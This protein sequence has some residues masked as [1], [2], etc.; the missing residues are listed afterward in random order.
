MFKKLNYSIY[1]T[2]SIYLL[3]IGSV[4]ACSS[5]CGTAFGNYGIGGPITTTPAY[6]L[7]QGKFVINTSLRY[8]NVD[9]FSNNTFRA[10]D[11]THTHA[12][13]HDSEMKTIATL[14][15]GITD[16]FTI[17][18]SY[19]YRFL[20]GL[21]T[22]EEDNNIISGGNSIG[23][24]DM[25]LLAKYR[26]L[27]PPLSQRFRLQAA[28]LAGIKIPTGQGNERDEEGFKLPADEQPGTG[29]WDPVMGL[30]L[31]L[32]INNFS[33]DTNVNYKLS[34]QGHQQTTVGDLISF[35]SALTYNFQEHTLFGQRI[36]HA[37]IF[38]MN[39]IWQEKLEESGI[40]DDGHGGLVIFLSPGLK[41]SI[42]DYTVLDLQVGL[43]IIS[44]LN[45]TQPN[46]GIQLFAG[47]SK[48]F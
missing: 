28:I 17:S 29:S 21:K 18:L 34:T 47:I 35:N 48:I 39:G 23:F 13:S 20:Y 11:K 15:Y 42:N 31:S 6:T 44:D 27:D 14:A 30:A 43:P 26:F 10:L 33:L 16:D 37:A 9:Q 25:T 19:P 45:G 32:P 24:G 38:E 12:H 36:K 1:L 5:G 7:P 4:L 41:T 46:T 22:H 3:S 8:Q 2:L 40:K